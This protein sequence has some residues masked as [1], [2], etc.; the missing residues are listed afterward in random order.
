MQ[1]QVPK[2]WRKVK[3]GE[4]ALLN[5]SVPLD[6]GKYPYIPMEDLDWDK[7]YVSESEIKE[8]NG[9]A[10]FEEGDVL[11]ARITPCLENGKIG[12]VKNLTGGK[13]FGSTEFF[14]IRGKDN[15]SETD[16][17]YY[18]CRTYRL[19][20]TAINSMVGVS[21]RQRAY[22]DPLENYEL[23]LP[24]FPTQ[25]K[26]AS[27]L[28]SFDDKIELN[29]KIAKTLEEMAQ[30]IFKEWFVNFRFPGHEKV[31]KVDSELGRIPEGW[32]VSNISK[33][34]SSDRNA[35]VDGPFGTQ[36]KIAE[37]TN[38]GIPII[39][40]NYLQDG[41]LD[42]GFK[43]FISEEKFKR[44]KRSETKNGDIVISKT[45][46]LG[47]IAIV[48][49]KV[50]RA[51][52]VSRLAKL[53]VDTSKTF[54]SFI[55]SYFIKLN[56][57]GYWNSIASGSTMPILN[58]SHLNQITFVLPPYSLQEKF[59]DIFTSFYERIL[60]IRN[61]NQKLAAARDLLLPKLMKGEIRA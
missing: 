60:E 14:I 2:N 29:N 24:D 57:S 54:P 43:H 15:V 12:K 58:L 19:R 20:Q 40:M 33:I 4:I 6:K 9:G 46:T 7:K 38:S 23:D 34:K 53:T 52:I 48:P 35:L 31:K 39:E 49:N 10:R 22:I 11:F 16:Y 44:V 30:A 37:Y 36:M 55:Y 13:G 42:V 45:G 32:E 41:Y 61:E 25:K 27:V 56:K 50:K 1:N 3:L 18:L 51:I 5:P 21:G 8:F 26:I 28:S 17:L 59:N 47:L